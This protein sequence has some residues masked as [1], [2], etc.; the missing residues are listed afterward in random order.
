VGPYF[1]RGQAIPHLLRCP[2]GL[3]VQVRSPRRRASNGLG[4]GR[5]RVGTRTL[6]CRPDI[7]VRESAGKSSG[8]FTCF[9]LR[10]SP[11]ILFTE[12][13]DQYQTRGVFEIL[14]RVQKDFPGAEL[15]KPSRHLCISPIQ[16]PHNPHNLHLV[17]PLQVRMDSSQFSYFRS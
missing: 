13:N 9:P 16:I 8:R 14:R 10:T 17:K 12:P 11:S 2:I 6:E 5:D 3:P 7:A 15:S 1:R 4:I